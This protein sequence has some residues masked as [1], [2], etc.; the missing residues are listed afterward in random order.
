MFYNFMSAIVDLFLDA[1]FN[2]N[3][4]LKDILGL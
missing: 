2:L 3:E 1:Q 4:N